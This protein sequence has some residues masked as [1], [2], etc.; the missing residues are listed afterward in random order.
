MRIRIRKGFVAA[1][2]PGSL[3][4]IWIR[5]R[6]QVKMFLLNFKK[7]RKNLLKSFDENIA[8]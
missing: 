1:S 8:F 7:V 4:R 6:I 5:F 3:L 2:K